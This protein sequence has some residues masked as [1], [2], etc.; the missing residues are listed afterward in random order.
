MSGVAAGAL[1]IMA[2]K[3]KAEFH[4][5]NRRTS[6]IPDGLM[7]I[8]VAPRSWHHARNVAENVS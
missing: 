8:W 6:R 5:R 2:G 4:I 7:M 3:D 1:A